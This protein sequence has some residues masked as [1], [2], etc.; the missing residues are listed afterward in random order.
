MSDIV[1]AQTGEEQHEVPPLAEKPLTTVAAGRASVSLS[2]QL[3]AGSPA[4]VEDHASESTC[5]QHKLDLVFFFKKEHTKWVCREGGQG[6]GKGWKRK[7]KRI[8]NS[9]RT[10]FCKKRG[11]I[12]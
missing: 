6:P 10:N 9:Q 8:P 4:P 7:V 5:E 1:P 12:K 2:L 3:L 11:K